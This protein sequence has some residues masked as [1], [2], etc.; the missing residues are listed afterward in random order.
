MPRHDEGNTI[1]WALRTGAP[2]AVLLG[3]ATSLLWHTGSYSWRLMYLARIC[4]KHKSRQNSMDTVPVTL[5]FQQNWALLFLDKKITDFLFLLLKSEWGISCKD[6]CL[7]LVPVSGSSS[8]QML[9]RR[10]HY[11][12]SVHSSHQPP[13]FAE[14]ISIRSYVFNLINVLP[15]AAHA[16]TIWSLGTRLS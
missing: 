12:G 2:L 10:S 3:T 14:H 1:L 4:R 16:D 5:V 8:G 15:A 13:L 11:F 7:G 9:T 6:K